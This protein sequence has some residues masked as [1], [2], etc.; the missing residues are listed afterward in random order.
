MWKYQSL[1]SALNQHHEHQLE[2]LAY[3][4]KLQLSEMLR[5]PLRS[6]Q[7]EVL[8]AYLLLRYSLHMSQHQA[9]SH[10]LEWVLFPAHRAEL[11]C[12]EADFY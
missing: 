3:K 1:C 10:T 12:R 5:P 7:R 2:T 9:A 8:S 11:S 4:S 6:R